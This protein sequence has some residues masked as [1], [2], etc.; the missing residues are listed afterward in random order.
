MIEQ[1]LE[2][3]AGFRV[4]D[5]ILFNRHRNNMNT[6]DHVLS[7]VGLERLGFG[8]PF[9]IFRKQ[10][11]L[12]PDEDRQQNDGD[13]ARVMRRIRNIRAITHISRVRH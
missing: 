3:Q 9:A 1:A 8:L 5:L 6:A 4:F 13:V 10:P 12:T 11:H 2:S 7:A